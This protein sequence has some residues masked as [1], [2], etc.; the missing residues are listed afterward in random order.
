MG[1]TI[2]D[3]PSRIIVKIYQ[4]CPDLSTVSALSR[5][6]H[7]YNDLWAANI[8]LICT[9]IQSRD[10]ECYDQACLLFSAQES[11]APIHQALKRREGIL[12]RYGRSILP[13]SS[14]S[15]PKSVNTRVM[16]ERLR[17]FHSNAFTCTLTLDRFNITAVHKDQ[18]ITLPYRSMTATERERFIKAYYRVTALATLA[19]QSIL[20]DLFMP[21]DMLDLGQMWDVMRWLVLS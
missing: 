20:R 7:F 4:F 17:R 12:Q 18:K 2:A 10:I 19:Q 14:T 1:R 21:L 11:V 8:P 9:T 15:Q 13:G 16:V 3:L 5:T 6:S